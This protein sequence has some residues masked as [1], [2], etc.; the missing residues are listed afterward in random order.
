MAWS[1][2]M[3]LGESENSV[4]TRFRTCGTGSPGTRGISGGRAPVYSWNGSNSSINSLSPGRFEWKFRLVIFMLIVEIDGWGIS[5]E[6]ALRLM[7]LD[8]TDNKSTLVQVMA[9]CCQ[10]TSHYPSQCWLRSMSPYGIT[11]PH[12]ELNLRLEYSRRYRS[13]PWLLMPWLL[14][15]PGHQ[16]PWYWLCR[17]NGSLSSTKKDFNK[18]CHLID[19]QWW[20]MCLCLHV[21]SMYVSSIKF[22]TS[23]V[24]IYQETLVYHTHSLLEAE[25]P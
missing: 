7:L 17:I 12:N 25:L 13:I 6:I 11:R 2:L 10:A 14:P 3:N 21:S 19:K 1:R 24:N 16:Q 18:L 20:E 22:S 5:C 15:S 9:R 4:P 8:L 23:M